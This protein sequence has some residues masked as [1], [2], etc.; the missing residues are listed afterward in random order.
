MEKKI[1]NLE[2]TNIEV[3]FKKKKR[4]KC[5]P[6]PQEYISKNVL[7]EENV[8]L[9]FFYQYEGWVGEW[10]VIQIHPE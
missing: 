1:A 6:K 8:K 2:K 7:S 9:W 3:S 10:G 4:K 5:T